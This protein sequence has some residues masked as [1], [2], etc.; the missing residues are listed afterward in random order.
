MHLAVSEV[1]PQQALNLAVSQSHERGDC[2][3]R[4]RGLRQYR[5]YRVHFLQRVG[6]RF[7]RLR[8]VRTGR[9]IPS[10]VLPSEIVLL[11]CQSENSAYYALDVLQGVAAQLCSPADFV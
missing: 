2:K 9:G 6:I 1:L 11:L 7:L 3:S 8:C 5:Q 10:G 4:C